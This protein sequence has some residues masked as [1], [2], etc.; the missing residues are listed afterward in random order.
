VTGAIGFGLRPVMVAL[1]LISASL[2]SSPVWA[3]DDGD[4]PLWKGIG[5]IFGPV[6]GFTG[7]GGGEKP[8]PI[9]YREHGKLVL[10]PNTELPPPGASATAD[11]SWPVNQ[12]IVRKKALKDAGKKE[13]AGV[14]D[15]RLRY[16][17][18]F[19][20]NEPVTIRAVDPNGQT[21][22]C[23]S[24]CGG[25]S[26][27]SMLSNLNPLNWVGMGKSASATLGPEPDREWLTDPPKGFRAPVAATPAGT[28]QGSAK[29]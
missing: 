11:P 10:P 23:G 20:P 15:A 16:T 21:V 18:G 8:P 29:N 19:P 1:A 26:S 6:V 4:A 28:A 14:G 5:A 27:P 7:L 9:E 24:N 22:K 12:E 3:G 13:I 2:V 17:H 25:G